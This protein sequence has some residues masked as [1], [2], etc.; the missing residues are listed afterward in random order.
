M[1]RVSTTR[2]C[3]ISWMLR[4]EPCSLVPPA[5]ARAEETRSITGRGYMP[6]VRTWPSTWIFIIGWLRSWYR[7]LPSVRCWAT[8]TPANTASS[9]ARINLDWYDILPPLY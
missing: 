6:G 7:S 2:P 1:S 9:A 4:G 8:D 3:R 5:A